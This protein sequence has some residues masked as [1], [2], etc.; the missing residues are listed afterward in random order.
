MPQVFED[1]HFKH[2]ALC[3]QEVLQEIEDE[4]IEDGLD[5]YVVSTEHGSFIWR[6]VERDRVKVSALNQSTID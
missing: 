4:L 5:E 6:A 3:I 1:D 2:S